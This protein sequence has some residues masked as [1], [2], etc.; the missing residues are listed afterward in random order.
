MCDGSEKELHGLHSADSVIC[1]VSFKGNEPVLV[2]S[3]TN[4][5]AGAFSAL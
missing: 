4:G 5:A 1:A 2:F 3:H